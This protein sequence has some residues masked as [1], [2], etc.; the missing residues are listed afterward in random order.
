MRTL[1]LTIVTA[2]LLA[3]L[4]VLA[5][6]EAAESDSYLPPPSYRSSPQPAVSARAQQ[7]S[8]ETR[9][10][11]ARS[12]RRRPVYGQRFAGPRFFGLF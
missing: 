7:T 1:A 5:A 4:S 6:D 12:A 9:R 10:R 11:P 2:I 8:M 3:P